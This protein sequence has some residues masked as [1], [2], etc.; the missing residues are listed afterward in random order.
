MSVARG[1]LTP[2]EETD[3]QLTGKEPHLLSSP[4]APEEEGGDTTNL[5]RPQSSDRWSDRIKT[6]MKIHSNNSGTL[7]SERS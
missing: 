5:S 1:R 6:E 2:D 4:P 3:R 7:T